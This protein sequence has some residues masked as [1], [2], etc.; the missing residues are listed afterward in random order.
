VGLKRSALLWALI[1]ANLVAIAGVIW[2]SL[3]NRQAEAPPPLTFRLVPTNFANL[4]G[5][6]AG[7]PRAALEAFRRSCAEIAKRPLAQ[8][9][10]WAGYAGTVSAWLPACKALPAPVVSDANARAFTGYYE[11]ELSGSRLPTPRYR[12][13]IYGRPRDLISADLGAFRQSLEGQH[14]WGRVEGM[15]LVPYAT[16]ADIDARGLAAAPVLLYT[17]DPVSAFFL[18]IQGSGLVKLNTGETLRLA[19][20]AKNGRP[21]TP[22]GRVLIAKGALERKSVSMQSIRGWLHAHPEDAKRVM[23]ADQSFVFF[24]LAP[25]GDPALGSP[26]TEGIPI[27]A[28]A[29]LA[30]DPRFHAFGTPVY[31]ATTIPD[32][33]PA[34]PDRGFEK[35][36]IAQDTGGAIKGA[37]RGDIFFGAGKDAEAIAGRL[38]AHGQFFVLVPKATAAALGSG[39]DFPDA[40][41]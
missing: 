30:V 13:P 31:V 40:P 1:V 33:D 36:L 23:E 32:P 35:L 4:P 26:G 24:E 34:K 12:V 10:G 6:T 17:D 38:N 29:S 2:I 20:A 11:P 8:P 3:R 15:K 5:W 18:Q 21:Y 39:K 7:D 16:R 41:S 9:M 37:A 19:Y 25:L 28:Q 22:V 14:V 27:A